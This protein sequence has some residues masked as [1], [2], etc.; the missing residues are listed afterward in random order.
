MPT[1]FGVVKALAAN[2]AGDLLHEVYHLGSSVIKAQAC[3]LSS[4][5]LDLLFH[6]FIY[7]KKKHHHRLLGTP[8]W[9]H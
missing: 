4:E 3:V 6:L 8:T 1:A 5:G 2:G 9:M 7:K